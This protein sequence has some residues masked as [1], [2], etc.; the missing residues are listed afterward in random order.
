MEIV[1]SLKIR[2]RKNDVHMCKVLL[3][4]IYSLYT[5]KIIFRQGFASIIRIFY[6]LYTFF[7]FLVIGYYIYLF[8]KRIVDKF[9]SEI[10]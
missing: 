2:L 10:R 7:R 3:G 8:V 5:V 6:I 9:K 1:F 4:I